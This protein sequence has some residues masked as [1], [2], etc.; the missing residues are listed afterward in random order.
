MERRTLIIQQTYST[1]VTSPFSRIQNYTHY[2]SYARRLLGNVPLKVK[3]HKLNLTR[4]KPILNTV[5]L[6]C[7]LE[8]GLAAK[9]I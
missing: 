6:I 1:C 2:N 8:N 7:T 9:S 3:K 4:Y 5:V